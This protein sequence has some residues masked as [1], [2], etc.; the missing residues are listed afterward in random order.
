MEYLESRLLPAVSG[1][2]I[3]WCRFVDDVFSILP[4]YLN[5]NE[6]L[7]K[8][9]DFNPNI[10][11][12]VEVENNGQLPFLDVL[13]LRNSSNYLDFKVYRKPTH[14]NSYIHAFSKHDPKIKS[15][16]ISNI[17]LRAYNICSNIYIDEE[18]DY[19]FKSFTKLG[20]SNRLIM[21]AHFNARRTYFRVRDNNFNID[22]R[23]YLVLPF[24]EKSS[25]I[26]NMAKAFNIS[27]VNRSNSSL[28]SILKNNCRSSNDEGGAIY[29][30]KCQS[31][32]SCYIGESNC[33][34]KRLIQHKYALRNVDTNNAV[35]KHIVEEDHRVVVDD[36]TI[37]MR[38]NDTK[39]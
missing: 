25:D 22:D 39:E 34:Q 37:I 10:K 33:M 15:S 30:I 13:L 7:A 19:I 20:Y 23:K 27:I 28:E 14:S 16:T 6:F 11:F 8:L 2:V 29:Q 32:D 1:D 31:C 24:I 36:A 3:E 4:E 38:E 12:T 5:T 18:I 9:N 26:N 35:A 17:F 21:N